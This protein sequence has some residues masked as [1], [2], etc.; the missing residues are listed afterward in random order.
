MKIL[1]TCEHGGNEIPVAYQDYFLNIQDILNTH[2]GY[3]PGALDLFNYLKPKCDFY[4][5]STTSRLLVELNR[6]LHHRQ[7]FSK[8]TK[9]LPPAVKDAIILN[10]YLPFRSKVEDQIKTWYMAGETVLHVSIHTFT[11]VLEG[12]VR[13]ADVGFL[14]DPGRE[15]EKIL[16]MK[17]KENL[18]VLSP[19]L[20]VRLNYPY[21][22]KADGFT[23]YLR[24]EF[25]LRYLGIELEVNQKYSIENSMDSVIKKAIYSIL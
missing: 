25:P 20:K 16:V 5:A 10:H 12:A 18:K 22:G 21:L 8:W 4:M 1:F 9:N 17:W 7:L 15:K 2:R 11:P 24:K 13:T 6:S 14:Y 3:D 23:T 19:N